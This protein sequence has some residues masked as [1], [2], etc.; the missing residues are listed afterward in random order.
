V[1]RAPSDGYD[2]SRK[3]D[4]RRKV[5]ATFRDVLKRDHISVANANVLLMPSLEGDEIEVAMNAGFRESNLHVVDF[6]PAIVATLKR[7]YPRINTYG[8]SASRA[9]E[10][11]AREGVRIRCANFDFC[12]QVS[13][14][15]QRE[16]ETISMF[17]SWKGEIVGAD[18]SCTGELR[19]VF[20]DVAVVA[21]SQLRGREPRKWSN[22]A[23]VA[24]DELD[25]D[26]KSLQLGPLDSV[27]L[28]D[29][30]KAFGAETANRIRSNA[31]NE[32]SRMLGVL[33]PLS[34]RDRARVLWVHSWLALSKYEDPSCP[35]RCPDVT[36]VR[37][38]WYKSTNGQTMLWSINRIESRA[39]HIERG[40]L[41]DVRRKQL[42]LRTRYASC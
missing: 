40:Q 19:G 32:V 36:L 7:R 9:M 8:V 24:D 42:G 18:Y 37:A 3:R 15:L 16:L 12:N 28:T 22:G 20:E 10:R 6:E 33:R 5:W 41:A 26:L 2:F 38:E 14:P 1:R 31:L 25:V 30:A 27:M 39:S 23:D 4:Y 11:L 13:M 35:R 34:E 21:V 17:G 29:V